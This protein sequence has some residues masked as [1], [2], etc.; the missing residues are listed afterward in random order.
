MRMRS[1]L[2]TAWQGMTSLSTDSGTM[3]F[4]FHASQLL[5]MPSFDILKN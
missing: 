5:T 3:M 2:P 1:I 4:I